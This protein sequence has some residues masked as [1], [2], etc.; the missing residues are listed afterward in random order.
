[1]AETPGSSLREL[2]FQ[3]LDRIEDEG[4]GVV[5]ELC[6]RHP[7]HA[8]VLRQ[9][10]AQLRGVGLMPGDAPSAAETLP[11]RLGGFRLLQKLGGGGMG[12]VFLAEQ[13]GLQ[14]R[15]ALKLV[16]PDLLFFGGA[17]QRF[18]REVE[19]VA[20]LAHPGIVPVYAGGE[21]GGIPWYAMEL[22]RGASLEEVLHALAG[23]DPAALSGADLRT[24]IES[25]VRARGAAGEPER[26]GQDATPAPRAATA[27]PSGAAAP[28][29][30]A[31]GSRA[32]AARSSGSRAA[33]AA[34]GET[35]FAG[36]W[37]AACLRVARAVAEA[38]DHAHAQGVLH[39]DVKP[40]NVMLTPDGRVLLLDFGLAAAEGSERITGSGAHLGSLAWMSP[41]QVRGEHA[42]LDERTDVYSL[43]ATLFELLALRTPFAGGDAEGTRRRILEG[44]A[45]P[46][47][48]LNP[49]V[50]RDAETVCLMA[51]DADR[52]RRYATAAD[53]ADDLAAAL[54]LRPVQARRP[55]AWLKAR[56]WSQRNPAR[57]VAVAL[58]A[59]LLLGGPLGY[60]LVQARAVDRER[61]L[62]DK[63]GLANT[64][65][66]LA[67]G[68]LRQANAELQAG[69]VELQRA[70][71]QET[72]ARER[73]QR[74][75]DRSLA[76][77]DELLATVG[78]QDLRDLPG[79][80]DT[81]RGLLERALDYYRELQDEQ[82][83]DP[84]V[85]V[86][87]LRTR[88]S[89]ADLLRELGR[90]AEARPIY[91]EIVPQLRDLA[92]AAPGDANI[93]HAYGSALAQLGTLDWAEGR[94]EDARAR[95]TEA[96]DVLE[97]LARQPG[98]PP[99]V[100]HD[101]ALQH[102]NLGLL[103]RAA[104]DGQEALDLMLRAAALLE[105]A[106]A[107]DPR[108]VDLAVSHASAL[109][110]AA[111]VAESYADPAEGERLYRVA[112]ASLTELLPRAPRNRRVR[113]KVVDVA[114][115]FGVWLM[116]RD[117]RA[118]CE[119]TLR[120][121]V[122]AARSL[123]ADFPGEHDYRKALAVGALNLAAELSNQDRG[124]DAVPFA[125]EAVAQLERLVADQPAIAEYPYYLGTALSI[126]AGV[127]LETGST[128]RAV[129]ESERAVGQ[130]RAAL[131]RLGGSASVQA[132]LAS[133][134]YQL[135]D[136]RGADGDLAGS[137]A[138]ADEGRTLRSERADIVYQGSET[139]ARIA[140]A[141]AAD[142]AAR[143]RAEEAA[144]AELEL[145][146]AR[147]FNDAARLR[148]AYW[149]T[150][151]GR[152]EFEDLVARA[153]GVQP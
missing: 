104:G 38:L 43:G 3:V 128:Q 95:W 37:P 46:L 55:G 135:A 73:S 42:T 83:D 145:A 36:T 105:A 54:A 45:L 107:D 15:V 148:L 88:R 14:R 77:V 63:L 9:R 149:E 25:V 98:A 87:R 144:L 85:Q 35:L 115:N 125:E 150:L 140:G 39:R 110:E 100:T 66:D 81:R 102:L 139:F 44:R 19:A 96:R 136:S 62:N 93:G 92:A 27:S 137:L 118:E 114:A 121:G 78:S 10:I 33:R 68:E 72:V 122:D 18:R 60:G 20:R 16:R 26:A 131:A 134:L 50:P 124:P 89:I 82:P 58:G 51:M 40:S 80:E 52:E 120:T 41:E 57:A 70:L 21:D 1:M 127:H 29:A 69:R 7:Q 5:D 142:P 17:R 91:A 153:G 138:A 94:A 12:V 90:D 49:A 123:V 13:E 117:D 86:E 67:A 8:G 61:G 64:D 32:P 56:R 71:D 111:A 47:R 22:V 130:M 113:R 76:A 103:A 99:G 151:Q 101:L 109:A 119:A 133:S 11:E 112:W 79:F 34:A 132:Q 129:G 4:P 23:R 97:P 74:A 143:A 84:A 75:F 152:P 24:A 108:R 65:L 141:A 126:A 2:V 106:C 53:F 31:S 28:A 48:E 59:L 30:R 147:G 116:T 146:I 6:A